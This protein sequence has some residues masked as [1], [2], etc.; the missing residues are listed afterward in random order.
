M[1][2]CTW[3]MKLAVNPKPMGGS[4]RPGSNYASYGT[5]NWISQKSFSMESKGSEGYA[6]V[7]VIPPRVPELQATSSESYFKITRVWEQLQGSE[8]KYKGLTQIK[9]NQ[10]VTIKVKCVDEGVVVQQTLVQNP[11]F[12]LLFTSTCVWLSWRVCNIRVSVSTFR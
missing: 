4:L 12:N 7:L 3:N 2:G 8:N 5:L 1:L 10:R 9:T 6:K 11:Y